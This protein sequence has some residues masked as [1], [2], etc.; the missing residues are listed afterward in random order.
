MLTDAIKLIAGLAA[1]L[2]AFG[3]IIYKGKNT[4]TKSF[5]FISDFA[6]ARSSGKSD[7]E[8][9]EATTWL[10]GYLQKGN[11]ALHKTMATTRL[12]SSKVYFYL[13]GNYG[14]PEIV[15]LS[16]RRSSSSVDVPSCIVDLK[17]NYKPRVAINNISSQY[18]EVIGNKDLRI[19]QIHGCPAPSVEQ[20]SAIV[21]AAEDIDTASAPGRLIVLECNSDAIV[22]VLRNKSLKA[23]TDRIKAAA[24]R[25]V[26]L[27]NL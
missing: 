7:L 25:V 9:L 24:L 18:K 14:G 27:C 20:V 26:D 1:V 11:Y 8:R 5:D 22:A 12:R 16:T 19:W 21:Q 13:T 17:T 10:A 23:P 2:L 3:Y 6:Q 4:P 15:I